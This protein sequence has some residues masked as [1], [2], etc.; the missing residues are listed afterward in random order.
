MTN[1]SGKRIVIAGGSGFLGLSLAEHLSRAGGEVVILSRSRP[2]ADGRWTHL[3]W[4][5]RTPGEW[6]STL[7]GADAVVNLAGRTVNC[8]K[9]PDHQDEILRSRVESTRALG[10]AMRTVGSPPP[11][12][13]Q[14]STAH[15][16]GDP[17]AA[18]CTE[19]S[20]TGIGF[21]P[22]IGHA[23]EAAFAES[24]LPQQR[25][26]IMRTSFVI[27]RDRGAGGGALATLRLLARIGLGGRVGK[28]TQGMSWMHEADFNK[29]FSQAI[30]DD[31]MSGVYIASA[32]NPVSQVDFMRT[33]RQVVR[34][35]IGL[36]AFEWMVRI[37]APLVFRTDPELAL[38]GRYV[39][40]KRLAEA[41]FEFQFPTLEPALRDLHQ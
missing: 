4:D 30:T 21:A 20:A 12:W 26:V 14:M 29:L 41:G 18:I 37:G 3:F 9:T 28:G 13:V 33:L 11:V 6:V 36:P 25:G 22:T 15:I 7:D 10:A 2:Q 40:S 1:L 38:Y 19:D 23:W 34:M 35:P 24:K 8:I 17:P 27:G 31:S 5:G 16:Y 32:P 39:V